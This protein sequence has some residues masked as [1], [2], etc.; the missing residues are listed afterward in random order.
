MY[1]LDVTEIQGFLWHTFVKFVYKCSVFY[2]CNRV[3]LPI[4]VSNETKKTACT[5]R[6]KIYSGIV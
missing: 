5:L 4:K 1:D 2:L 3:K 6:I